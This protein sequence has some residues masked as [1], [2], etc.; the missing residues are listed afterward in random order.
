MPAFSLAALTALELPPPQL[1][2]AGATCGFG[3]VGLRLQPAT[4]EGIAYP[5]T[6][7]RNQLKETVIRLRA[8]GITVADLEVVAFRPETQAG[9]LLPS[10]DSGAALGAKL[11]LVACYDPEPQ[12]FLD[13]FG[14]Y[15]TMS[16]DLTISIEVPILR[17]SKT[18][19]AELRAHRALAAAKA[20][21]AVANR[22][23]DQPAALGVR[24]LAFP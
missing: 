7:N 16:R 14:E 17:L 5:L 21:T 18:L 10:L 23:N 6:N 13:R 2:E 22:S 19:N 4:P 8:T 1:V 3:Q 20:V 15:F 12:R 24:G 11:T 9:T